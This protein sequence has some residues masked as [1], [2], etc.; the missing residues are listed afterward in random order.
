MPPRCAYSRCALALAAAAAG[1]GIGRSAAFL[2]SQPSAV[3][4]SS[5]HACSSLPMSTTATAT[6]TATR[7]SGTASV[8]LA[9]PSGVLPVVLKKLSRTLT[10][11]L[12]Y[13]ASKSG[14][15]DLPPSSSASTSSSSDLATLSMQ[16]RQSRTAAIFT[17]D[18][19]ALTALVAEQ[20]SAR[21]DFPGPCP[22]I[23]CGNAEGIPEA[24][25][26]GAAAV[27]LRPDPYAASIDGAAGAAGALLRDAE[28]DI[29][30]DVRSA[31]DVAAALGL[32][33]GADAFLIGSGDV[34]INAVE[35]I[36]AAL[37]PGKSSCAIGTVRAMQDADGEVTAGR[38]LRAAGCASVL[39]R[40]AAVGDAEDGAYA[41]FAIG[42]LTSKASSEFN[43]SGLT[44]SANGHFGG[45]AASG[46]SSSGKKGGNRWKRD[47]SL[48]MVANSVLG[49]ALE[50][51]E[52]DNEKDEERQGTESSI[53]EIMAAV[54]MD[55][56]E[57]VKEEEPEILASAEEDAANEEERSD[58]EEAMPEPELIEA[59]TDVVP[60]VETEPEPESEPEPE[61]EL[62]SNLSDAAKYFLSSS[63]L[64]KN[65]PEA[66]AKS[67]AST[68]KEREDSARQELEPRIE[69]LGI[70]ADEEEDA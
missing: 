25:R 69:R 28:V 59:L 56:D 55:N 31:D 46:S 32:Q 34:D 52:E 41:Q 30:W 14:A 10:V 40:R 3:H 47:V 13:D 57:E 60:E 48:G 29:I 64:R 35:E 20:E 43:F 67:A 8:A 1:A 65:I 5:P 16:L 26:A 54:E 33:E 2:P 22:V 66:E 4:A 6:A 15:T 38:A 45:V 21:G 39:L 68:V 12:E 27:V 17:A 61:P 37:P 24:V 62:V 7:T 58:G 18:V 51:A 44:G 9:P 42:A 63:G 19:G 70:G 23:F 11:C 53:Q 50:E 36:V 49:N